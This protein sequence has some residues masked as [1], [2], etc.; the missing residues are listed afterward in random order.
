MAL[1]LGLDVHTASSD[2]GFSL[3]VDLSIS[4]VQV[5]VKSSASQQK[6]EKQH[7]LAPCRFVLVQK[8]EGLDAVAQSCHIKGSNTMDFLVNFSD[9][10]I[11]MDSLDEL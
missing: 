7:L 3:E 10:H 6:V 9:Y 5:S 11:I 2:T 1:T 4:A 8:S